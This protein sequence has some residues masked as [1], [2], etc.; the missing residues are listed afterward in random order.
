MLKPFKDYETTRAFS[1]FP[2]LPKGGYVMKIMG[3]AKK[4]NSAG[5]YLQ[6]GMDVAE[7]QYKDFYTKQYTNDTRSEKK[8]GCN[9]LLN[10]PK[11]DGSEK[12]GWTKSKFKTF[13]VALEE[14]N[15]G[16]HF[17][18]DES[19]WKGKIIGGLFNE[20]E[21]KANNGNISKTANFEKVCKAEDIRTGNYK[22]P[23]DKLLD[24]SAATPADDFI[25]IPEGI[26]EELPFN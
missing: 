23:E 1:E 8:W 20:R 2:K 12:D 24:K 15:S 13:T 26:T 18:W 16:Y 10:I 9:F 17:D 11:D 21:Y 7:G 19:K 3:I 22:L 6:I 4:I 25:S 5:E 14:S